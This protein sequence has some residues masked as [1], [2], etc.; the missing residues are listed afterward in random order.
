MSTVL[1]LGNLNVEPQKG[2]LGYGK[3]TELRQEDLRGADVAG[4]QHHLMPGR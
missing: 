1:R 2:S 3:P 4:T